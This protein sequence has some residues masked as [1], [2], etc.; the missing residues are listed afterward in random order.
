MTEGKS[1]PSQ[2]AEPVKEGNV[3]LKE[4]APAY[5]KAILTS[6][7]TTFPRLECPIPTHGRYDYLRNQSYTAGRRSFFFA[8]DLHQNV[9]LLPRLLGSVIEAIRFLGPSHCALSI[10]EGRSDD[11]TLEVL[12]E[13][14]GALEKE[15]IPYFL[16]SD[17]RD[18]LGESENRIEALAALRN[19]ALEPL[20]NHLD[21]YRNDTTVIFLN[22][23]A[24]CM[25][26]ILELIHQR[27]HQNADMTCAM[28][29]VN[30]WQ[31]PTFY[32][33]WIGRGI[34]G[35]SFFDIPPGGDWNFAW[36]LFWNHEPTKQRFE[37]HKPFQ[38]F[39]CWNG[40]VAFTALPLLQKK[41]KFR[42]PVEGECFQGE[43]MIYSK[44]MWHL[45]YG[46]IAVVP[47]VN[48]EY[49]DDG[50]REIKRLRGYVSELV[51]EE[52]DRIEW[53]AKPP[54]KVKCMTPMDSQDWR[55]WDEFLEPSIGS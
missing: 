31:D 37:N 53:E 11:G 5:V 51:D 25:E 23:V 12:Q 1:E 55:P 7:D 54:E 46:K 8:L 15:R 27:V 49:S 14:A 13:L 16:K 43:P 20:I 50:A 17:D 40:G 3:E 34:N 4:A 26:D 6:E 38:V 36:N 41:I 9:D 39:S 33:I 29:W 52:D 18:P 35:D 44:E 19:E 22:D 24:L 47:S 42:S 32:D 2:S 30:L 21:Q 45:G 10:V 28:D 48:L